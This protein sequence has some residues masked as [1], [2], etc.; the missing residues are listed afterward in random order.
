[1]KKVLLIAAV[2]GVAFTA[3]KGGS[4]K[5][6]AEKA[7]QD[8]VAAAKRAD[9]LLQA[10]KMQHIKDSTDAAKKDTTKAAAPADKK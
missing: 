2:A 9:S 5:A 4:D 6:D 3:C 1:M 8:S 10:A 7:K